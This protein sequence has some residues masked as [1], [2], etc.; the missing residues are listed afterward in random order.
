MRDVWVVAIALVVCLAESVLKGWFTL[1]LLPASLL[2][3]PLEFVLQRIAL[4]TQRRLDSGYLRLVRLAQLLSLVVAYV[5]LVGFG[6]TDD[7]WL[8]GIK[9][10]T[11]D[12]KLTDLSWTL[13][14]IATTALP[15]LTVWLI[16]AL[17]RRRD[18]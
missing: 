8:F 9:A 18:D 11:L 6:D 1:L 10:S 4:R 14:G 2:I 7:V 5:T 13:F 16:V 12:S 17:L 3:L 15:I